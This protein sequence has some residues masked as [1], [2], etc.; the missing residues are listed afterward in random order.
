MNINNLYEDS[1]N[2]GLVPVVLEDTSKG[3]RSF[4]LFSRMLR[5]RVIFLFTEFEP[6]MSKIIC[7]QLLF[8]EA[9]NP[10]KDISLYINSPGGMV[11]SGLAIID[12]MR[13]IAPDVST[14]V[15]GLAASMGSITAASGA[16]GKRY[17]LPNAR[18]MLHQPSAG[19][20]GTVT[21]MNI[22]M[23]ELLHTKEKLT[24]IYAEQL[25]IPREEIVKEMERDW[26][27]S[28][29]RAVEIGHADA[30]VT[31]RKK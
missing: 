31:R 27:L 23:Q 16:I 19:T 22:Y 17:I 8:L 7:A 5:D 2:A 28:P 9:E 18:V 30:I 10:D 12:T 4:D 20:R 11:D 29:E 24:N 6:V 3:E 14:T 21:D 13:F 15:M 25:K 26:W 1:V